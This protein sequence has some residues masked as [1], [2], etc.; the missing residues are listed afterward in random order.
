ME[1]VAALKSTQAERDAA[2]ARAMATLREEFARVA[3]EA[4]AGAQK[5]FA[6]Q[7]EE[8][9]KAHREAAT[10][11]LSANKTELSHL[12]TPV[13]ETLKRYQVELKAIEQERQNAYGGLTQALAGVAQGQQAVR[14]E[15]AR[16]ST[17]L[18]SSGKASGAWGEAQLRNVLEMGGLREGIDFDL[19]SSVTD[20]DDA[21]LRPDAVI[22]LPAG[23]TLVVDSKCSLN[24]Y[25]AACEAA[26]EDARRAALRRHAAAVKA[27][28]VGLA[29]K[30][31]WDKVGGAADFVV[32]FMPGENF[33]SAALDA[34]MGLLAG[35]M[36][37][38]VL[39]AGPINLLAL[40][41]TVSTVWRQEKLAKEAE[42]IGKEAAELYDRLGTM[43]DHLGKL[44]KN[45]GQSVGAYNAFVGALEGRVLPSARR[46]TQ[47]GV[48]AKTEIGELPV[49]DHSP[50]S[51]VARE[52]L[53]APGALAAE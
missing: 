34:D 41:R 15:A 35:A 36:D 30:A 27:H 20:E 18:R 29:S 52:L 9:L 32:L 22:R 43:A 7:A 44:G 51:P 16:L 42:A 6:D 45:L 25:M 49:L 11:N 39:L 53:P 14:E 24:D 10:A 31:Y 23:R 21:R 33:L 8:T 46:L 4:L 38:R 40:A 5:A 37:K 3:G 47:L 26:D 48:A 28:V 2:H 1:E 13:A 12:L 19:Q 17:A 50:R